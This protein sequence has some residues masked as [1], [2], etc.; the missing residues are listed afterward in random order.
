MSAS[1]TACINPNESLES[2]LLRAPSCSLMTPDAN[3][4][5]NIRPLKRVKFDAGD[6]STK[7][8]DVQSTEEREEKE[9]DRRELLEPRRLDMDQSVALAN[10][11]EDEE[12]EVHVTQPY[13]AE[14]DVEE[15]EIPPAISSSDST[16]LEELTE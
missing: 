15:G 13:P 10:P 1:S 7:E 6:A 14:D 5:V 2:V 3:K 12:E 8:E 11:S 4:R 16:C 9:D